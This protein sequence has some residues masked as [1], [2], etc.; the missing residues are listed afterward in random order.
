M[1]KMYHSKNSYE[2]K[3]FSLWNC[4]NTVLYTYHTKEKKGNVISVFIQNYIL[5]VTVCH[6]PSHC[7][8]F[9]SVFKDLSTIT[10]LFD[11]KIRFLLL[12]NVSYICF[13]VY[14]MAIR[15]IYSPKHVVL[16]LR[17]YRYMVK[18]EN[19]EIG[20]ILKSLDNCIILSAIVSSQSHYPVSLGAS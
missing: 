5:S 3:L 6:I 10:N 12:S 1:A 8:L 9:N 18:P 17:C 11:R 7:H 14:Q 13:L 16:S 15:C 20:R 19:S 4:H 2:R